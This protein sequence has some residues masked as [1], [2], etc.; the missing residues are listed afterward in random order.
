METDKRD[1]SGL[2]SLSKHVVY[3]SN[4]EENL[5]EFLKIS[6]DNFVIVIGDMKYGFKRSEL[7]KNNAKFFDIKKNLHFQLPQKQIVSE[8]S[9]NKLLDLRYS[10]YRIN[11][12]EAN[13][14]LS[15]ENGDK[16]SFFMPIFALE[17]YSVSEY[18]KIF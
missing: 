4:R 13:K 10:V 2:T 9:F 6:D 15:S 7:I 5:I 11:G 18:T 16:S 12:F 17:S 14:L 8:K 3:V 1:F